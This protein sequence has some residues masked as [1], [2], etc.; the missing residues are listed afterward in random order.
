M[1]GFCCVSSEVRPQHVR[2]RYTTVALGRKNGLCPHIGE[3]VHCLALEPEQTFLRV[4]VLDHCEAEAG[5]EVA[6][7]TAV[8]GRMRPG[9]RCLQLRNRLGTRIELCYLLLKISRGEE[10]HAWASTAE[11]RQQNRQLQEEIA[12][13]RAREEARAT[14]AREAH[15]HGDMD[16]G[17]Q[18]LG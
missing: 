8:L 13:H 1:G 18:P 7:E 16:H 9:Y 14:L 3:T 17:Q 12:A 5:V 4:A 6:F 10:D 15:E 2:T 11:L